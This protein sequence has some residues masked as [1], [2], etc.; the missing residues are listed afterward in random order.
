MEGVSS[1]AAV[2]LP[3]EY[4]DTR[5]LVRPAGILERHVAL[6]GGLP[7]EQALVQWTGEDDSLASWEPLDVVATHFP[8]LLGDKEPLNGEGVDTDTFVDSS[9]PSWGDVAEPHEAEELLES[10]KEECNEPKRT[11]R[12]RKKPAWFRDYVSI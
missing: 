2:E 7:V 12:L 9:Q 8:S 3:E 11:L 5:S 1:A 6:K 10:S 4:V